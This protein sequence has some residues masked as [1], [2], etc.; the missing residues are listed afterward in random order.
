MKRIC[1]F[2]GSN[3]SNEAAFQNAAKGL[4]DL[5][6]REKLGL[7]YG[8][9]SVGL[10][11]LLAQRMLDRGGEA[12]GVIPTAL[13]PKEIPHQKL[14]RLYEVSTMHERKQLMYDLSDGFIALPGGLGTLDELCEI[15][16]WAQLGLHRKPCGIL[17]V[18]GYFGPFLEFLDG[19][20]KR[21]LMKPSHRE[22]LLIAATPQALLKKLRAYRAPGL[23]KWI[24]SQ[25]V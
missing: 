21:E 6:V 16:T 23:K 3:P 22:L 7:V 20:V 9:A 10:M 12:I 4:A 18:G 15:L 17:N 2:C 8:G 24:R 25:E 14:T 5:L 13:F 19:A 11:G 1:V